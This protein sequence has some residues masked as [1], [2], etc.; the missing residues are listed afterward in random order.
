M[1]KIF[2]YILFIILCGCEVN[3]PSLPPLDTPSFSYDQVMQ[4]Q[5]QLEKEILKMSAEL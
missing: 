5:K 1:K 3:T 4:Q 2:L